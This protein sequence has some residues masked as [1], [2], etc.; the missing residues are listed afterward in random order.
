MYEHDVVVPDK[1]ALFVRG[2]ARI[3]HPISGLV[4]VSNSIRSQALKVFYSRNEF[5]L[6]LAASGHKMTS[7]EATQSLRTTCGAYVGYLR[8][9]ELNIPYMPKSDLIRAQGW[10]PKFYTRFDIRMSPAVAVSH[11]TLSIG[12]CT[13]HYP[14]LPWAKLYLGLEA[15]RQHCVCEITDKVAAIVRESGKRDGDVL[16]R[17]VEKPLST[18]HAPVE[19]R[20]CA[21]CSKTKLCYDTG[22]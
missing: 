5:K 15:G 16:L 11:V 1:I 3:P 2:R 4:S 22:F 9:V 7:A 13:H 10:F 17:L 6:T 19:I 14:A 8:A 18:S 21:V 12:H 20:Y